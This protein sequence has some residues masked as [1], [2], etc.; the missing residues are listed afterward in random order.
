MPLSYHARLVGD[1]LRTDAYER[2]LR[3]LVRPGDVVLDVGAGSGILSLLAAKRG[4]RV[5]AVESMPVAR[6]AA[7]LAERHGLPITV[8]EQ[9]LCRMAPIEPVDL[10]VSDFLGCFLVDDG[11]LPAIAAAAAWARPSARYCPSRV[12]LYVAPV[13]DFSLPAIEQWREPL[14][15]LDL[16]LLEE[17]ALGEL[18]PG[19][20]PPSALLA[21]P[22]LY[23]TFVPPG[24]AP[25]FDASLAF[26]VERP[27][28]LRALAGWFEADLADE[29]TLS[30]APGFETHWGQQLFAL[31]EVD[32]AAGEVV[33][34]RLWL[35]GRWRWQGTIG[36]RP[37]AIVGSEAQP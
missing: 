4:A 17:Q 33:R 27:G 8:H 14:Y 1:L 16:S 7:A 23:A 25:R 10:V 11:M 26:T 34:C 28:R 37:F 35:D 18:F 31:P 5:H 2:A 30:T 3:R 20:L 9:D 21:P 24:P 19:N 12:R 36:E 29:V 13:G 32:V 6:L 15:G 22:A